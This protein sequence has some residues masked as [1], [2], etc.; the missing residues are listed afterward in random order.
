MTRNTIACYLLQ[1][2]ASVLQMVKGRLTH[3]GESCQ[4]GLIRVENGFSGWSTELIS[5]DPPESWTFVCVS[6]F[7]KL[8][9]PFV[10][11][12]AELR[13]LSYISRSD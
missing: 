3:R 7:K 10:C 13:P 6:Q 9:K 8:Y 11:V 4:Q 2:Q 12:A 5:W 1:N